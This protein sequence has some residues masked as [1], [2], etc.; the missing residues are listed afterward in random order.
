MSSQIRHDCDTAI[1]QSDFPLVFEKF[2]CFKGRETKDYLYLSLS[3]SVFS[4]HTQFEMSV[5]ALKNTDTGMR[6]CAISSAEKV[7]SENRV[8]TVCKTR[9]RSGGLSARRPSSRWWGTE[10]DGVTTGRSVPKD[11]RGSL[12]HPLGSQIPS[13]FPPR[14]DSTRDSPGD[15]RS[16]RARPR[17]G[18]AGTPSSSRFHL[19]SMLAAGAA[20]AISIAV[21]AAHFQNGAGG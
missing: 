4:V 10:Q 8:C 2:L 13:E 12:T 6:D 20:S 11:R 18:R 15:S 7:G 1:K 16:S 5:H 14:F 17:E 3:L 21:P 19:R 9:S